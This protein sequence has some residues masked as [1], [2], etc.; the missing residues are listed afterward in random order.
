MVRF[1]SRGVG[2]AGAGVHH[3]GGAGRDTPGGGVGDQ[4]PVR[5][6]DRGGLAGAAA[7]F[8]RGVSECAAQPGAPVPRGRG[9]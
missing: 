8:K 5:L 9:G 3:G 4:L 7:S 1:A 6:V 2:A